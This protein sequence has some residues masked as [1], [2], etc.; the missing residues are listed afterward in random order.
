MKEFL[1]GTL[2]TLGNCSDIQMALRAYHF[3][4]R[5]FRGPTEVQLNSWQ[6]VDQEAVREWKLNLLKGQWTVLQYII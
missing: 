1:A 6:R 4:D 3:V 5:T 2:G